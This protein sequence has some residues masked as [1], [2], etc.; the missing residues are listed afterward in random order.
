MVATVPFTPQIAGRNF[1][2]QP[3]GVPQVFGR[4]VGTVQIK[5]ATGGPRSTSPC[6]W[7]GRKLRLQIGSFKLRRAVRSPSEMLQGK[8]NLWH[9]IISILASGAYA[10][11]HTSY[12]SK[13]SISKAF[14]KHPK[15][16]RYQTIP[17]LSHLQDTRH[18]ADA[19][20][21]SERARNRSM[22]IV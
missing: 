16:M 10:P 3:V 5:R 21:P 14:K 7:Q 8:T 19:S 13:T 2:Q 17:H 9:R 20:V 22:K 1:Q 4:A 6:S 11:F 12:K 15:I 18:V